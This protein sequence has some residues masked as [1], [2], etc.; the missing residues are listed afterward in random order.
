MVN[1]VAPGGFTRLVDAAL[2]DGEAKDRVR[3]LAPPEKVSLTYAWL[4][5]ESCDV[6]GEVF[7]AVGGITTRIFWGQ[8]R[9][10]RASSPEDL[11]DHAHEVMDEEDYWIPA[12]SREDGAHWLEILSEQ[13]KATT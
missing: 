6:T 4:A 8:T 3:N 13:S 9:G 12:G 11:R 2:P 10:Y 5:H 1:V 7:A